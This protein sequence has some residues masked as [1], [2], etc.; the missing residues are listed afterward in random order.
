MRCPLCGYEFD[1]AQE[2]AACHQ[3]CPFAKGCNMV[4]CPN[5]GYHTVD[6][7]GSSFLL[8]LKKLMGSEEL[9]DGKR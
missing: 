2:K 8:W 5:C 9:T 6:A 7:S 3:G 1:P 4:R